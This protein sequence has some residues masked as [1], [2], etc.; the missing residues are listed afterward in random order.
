MYHE[1]HKFF[2]ENL[3]NFVVPGVITWRTPA[4]SLALEDTISSFNIRL[5]ILY[6][7]PLSCNRL[8]RYCRNSS[9]MM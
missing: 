1:I 9:V 6:F 8:I 2:G 7:L 3:L 5:N 4:A